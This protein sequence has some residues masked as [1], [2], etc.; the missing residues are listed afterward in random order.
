MRTPERL[1]RF[2]LVGASAFIV[3]AA[4]LVFFVE[5][6][7]FASSL[8]KNVANVLAMEL[9]IFYNFLISRMWTWGDAP[10][11]QEGRLAAQLAAFN[12]AA[13]AGVALRIVS[14][15]ALES[16]QI[17]YLLNLTIGVVLAAA[18]DFV[19]YDRLIFKRPV[20]VRQEW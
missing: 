7:G 19:L 11:L 14:F 18:L 17:H 12:G 10:R 15:A 2:L 1:K 8:L 5:T 6:L 3:N 4:L 20:R 13:L 9:S 16:R